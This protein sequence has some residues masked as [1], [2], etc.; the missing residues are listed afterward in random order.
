MLV[1]S[2]GGV[3]AV[4]VV[5]SLIP[6]SGYAHPEGLSRAD[7]HTGLLPFMTA[8]VAEEALD[9]ENMITKEERNKEQQNV[10]CVISAATERPEVIIHCVK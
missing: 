4:V 10:Y 6:R 5:L 7:P 9:N 8:A 2:P 1:V 3:V